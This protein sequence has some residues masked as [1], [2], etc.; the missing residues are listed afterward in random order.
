[1]GP[2][3]WWDH[4]NNK[5]LKLN[6]NLKFAYNNRSSNGHILD[7][8]V[9]ILG[10]PKNLS[11]LSTPVVVKRFCLNVLSKHNLFITDGELLTFK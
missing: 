4:K 6:K 1:M 7:K 9:Y 3:K 10:H 8:V 5:I 11:S 2:G